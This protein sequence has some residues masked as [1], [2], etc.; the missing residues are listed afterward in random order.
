MKMDKSIEKSLK[1]YIG[2][3]ID[4]VQVNIVYKLHNIAKDF[5]YNGKPRNYK[6][7]FE[8]YRTILL[9]SN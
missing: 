1:T 2:M 3:N 9:C 4:L 8:I 5:K 7:K 6:D